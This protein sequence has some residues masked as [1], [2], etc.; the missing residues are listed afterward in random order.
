[1]ARNPV[2]PVLPSRNQMAVSTG[3]NLV[4]AY[5]QFL[6]GIRGTLNGEAAP[7]KLPG[8]FAADM[9]PNQPQ[10]PPA[11]D[12]PGGLIYCVQLAAPNVHLLI[13]DSVNWRDAAG[14]I[15]L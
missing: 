11:A 6:D 1:M 15:V 12:W 4:P 2:Q 10:L 13:S 7:H 5:H 3:G 14:N 8:Y 9:L